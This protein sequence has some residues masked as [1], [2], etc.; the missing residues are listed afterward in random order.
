VVDWYPAVPISLS[1]IRLDSWAEHVC[2]TRDLSLCR[3]PCFAY[4]ALVRRGVKRSATSALALRQNSRAPAALNVPFIIPFR[5]NSF[6]IWIIC[7][8]TFSRPGSENDT[9]E[10]LLFNRKLLEKLWKRSNETSPNRN[11]ALKCRTA[12]YI[13]ILV[14]L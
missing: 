3:S 9:L 10:K 2:R 5:V 13:I 1:L 12:S 11:Y 14:Q 8:P 7:T 4:L 6:I